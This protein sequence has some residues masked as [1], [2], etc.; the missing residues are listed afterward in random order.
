[1]S[2]SAVK[3]QCQ[4]TATFKRQPSLMYGQPWHSC[5]P[6]TA[7]VWLV[8]VAAYNLRPTSA[9]RITLMINIICRIAGI[10]LG[11]FLGHSRHRDFHEQEPFINL[12]TNFSLLTMSMTFGVVIRKTES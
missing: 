8:V 2:E 5:E 4:R 7:K 1:V 9:I 12:H 11:H 6:D 10:F 3:G